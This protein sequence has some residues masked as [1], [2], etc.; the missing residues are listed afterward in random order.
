MKAPQGLFLIG[1]LYMGHPSLIMGIIIAT[2]VST[3]FIGKVS[4]KGFLPGKSLV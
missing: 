3:C 4:Y 2:R 1:V